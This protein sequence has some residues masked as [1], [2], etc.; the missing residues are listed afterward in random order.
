MNRTSS[1]SEGELS[2]STQSVESPPA[3]DVEPAIVASPQLGPA[4]VEYFQRNGFI[5]VR[6]LFTD[7]AVDGIREL[8]G[9]QMEQQRG[10][11]T[12]P[13]SGVAYRLHRT[14]HMQRILHDPT[15]QSVLGRL[16]NT[17]VVPTESQAFE[18]SDGNSGIPW[19]Y[20]YISFG[21]IRA[22]DLGFTLW[23]PLSPIDAENDG[24]GMAYVPEYLVSARHAFDIGSLLAPDLD[25]GA[26]HED[27][28]GAIGQVQDAMEPLLERY[29]I[30]DSFDVGDA[31]LFNK[32]VWHRSSPLRTRDPNRK[33]RLG[34][35]MRFVTSDARVDRS[36]WGAEYKFG[37]GIGTGHRK[38]VMA[39]TEDRFSRVLDVE[40]DGLIRSSADCP[41][42]FPAPD[43]ISDR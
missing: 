39:G 12:G 34:I 1:R 33:P 32:F 8:A 11:P 20:G 23:I 31:F 3:S 38:P 21:Y 13:M 7:H 17:S 28:I 43:A 10:G 42:V 2:M 29:K 16:T 9:Q 30:E 18:L 40:H 25:A 4:E 27:L 41:L 15:F 22:R 5:R 6:N 36:R 37:G 19:H 26:D 35:A 24:G 14:P